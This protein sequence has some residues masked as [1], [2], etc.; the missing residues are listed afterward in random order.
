ML[1]RGS[2]DLARKNVPGSPYPIRA[3]TYTICDQYHSMPN[4]PISA[5]LSC[6]SCLTQSSAFSAVASSV[7]LSID[8]LACSTMKIDHLTHLQK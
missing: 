1:F 6:R 8:A 7:S 3:T 2:Y 5:S 4:R